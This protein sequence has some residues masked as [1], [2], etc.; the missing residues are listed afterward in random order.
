MIG[1]QELS[2]EFK[3]LIYRDGFVGP[4]T[5]VPLLPLT[6]AFR[7]VKYLGLKRLN[8]FIQRECQVKWGR[9]RTLRDQKLARRIKGWLLANHEHPMTLVIKHI[10]TLS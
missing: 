8:I 3:W 10:I 2:L 4:R 5:P 1:L 7:G 6:T 9:D